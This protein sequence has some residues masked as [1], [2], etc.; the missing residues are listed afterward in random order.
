MNRFRKIMLA[1]LMACLVLQSGTIRSMAEEKYTYMVTFYAGDKG[2]F[3][4]AGV[5]VSSSSGKAQVNV[6]STMITVT[7]L[8]LGDRVGLSAASGGAVTLND[9]EK[10]YVKGIRKSGYDNNTVSASSFVVTGDEDYV[11]AY[12]IQGDMAAYTVNFQDAAG[13]T[14]APS[15]THYGNVGDK[16]V[17]AFLYVDGYV[18]DAYNLTKTLVSDESQNVFTFVYSPIPPLTAEAPANGG[19]TTA[20]TGTATGTGTGTAAGTGTAEGTGEE[21]GGGEE[22]AG[23]E[24]NAGE[25]NEAE[26]QELQELGEE[27]VPQ[28]LVDL[29]E[30]QKPLSNVELPGTPEETSPDKASSMLG[31]VLIGAVCAAAIGAALYFFFIK[32]KKS[33]DQ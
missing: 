25:P 33:S 18:P 1:L 16:P 15:E 31:P 19:G 3:T 2:T 7:G 30:E 10:Y 26:E 32:K 14:L 12:G 23:N 9:G 20:G 5:Q 6:G 11:V 24:E 17:V 28:E 8:E 4:G 22:A 27:S 13:N 29:D 21:G